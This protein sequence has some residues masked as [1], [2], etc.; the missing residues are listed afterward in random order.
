[1]RQEAHAIRRGHTGG[2]RRGSQESA[3]RM[4]QTHSSLGQAKLVWLTDWPDVDGYE[5]AGGWPASSRDSPGDELQPELVQNR[6]DRHEVAGPSGAEV[7]AAER[8]ALGLV[9]GQVGGTQVT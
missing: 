9:L 2:T 5:L 4:L 3:E 7:R 1:M 8:N 6:V